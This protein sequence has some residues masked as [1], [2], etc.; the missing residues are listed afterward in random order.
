MF[1]HPDSSTYF[2]LFKFLI[3]VYVLFTQVITNTGD[4][5]AWEIKLKINKNNKKKII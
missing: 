3:Y 5:E 1:H 4:F 2:K